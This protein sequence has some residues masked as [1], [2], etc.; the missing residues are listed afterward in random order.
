ME[1][2][3]RLLRSE[4]A[5]MSVLNINQPVKTLAVGRLHPEMNN[6]VIIVGTPSH[7]LAY[8]VENNSD[9]F[10]KEVNVPI[11]YSQSPCRY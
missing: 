7:V 9:L 5:D 8:D 1:S 2:G 10:Y 11:Y 3:G 6:D 4:E